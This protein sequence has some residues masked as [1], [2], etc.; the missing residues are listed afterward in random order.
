MDTFDTKHGKITLLKNEAYISSS[1]K[2]G[3]YWDIDTLLKLK[4][5]IDPNR[6]ILEIGGHCGTSTVIYASFLNDNNLVHVFEPQ[7]NLHDILL[8]NIVKT[9][10]KIK[11]NHTTQEYFATMEVV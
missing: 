4:E 9:I 1:F 6:N 10:Y 11:L 8:Q 3:G 5:Y 2:S 7:K